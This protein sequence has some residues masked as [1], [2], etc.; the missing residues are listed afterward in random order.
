LAAVSHYLLLTDIENSTK[1]IGRVGVSITFDDWVDERVVDGALLDVN[2]NPCL[3]QWICADGVN[4]PFPYSEDEALYVQHNC[5]ISLVHKIRFDTTLAG[6]NV[7]QY[8]T[9]DTVRIVDDSVDGVTF[10]SSWI[11]EKKAL[12]EGETEYPLG[13]DDGFLFDG[14]EPEWTYA[15]NICLA[16]DDLTSEF[17]TRPEI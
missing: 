13:N 15:Y 16:G 9:D 14:A 7:L 10:I 5:P 11:G 1:L 17:C 4:R 8:H 2:Q 3:F 12:A 6:D